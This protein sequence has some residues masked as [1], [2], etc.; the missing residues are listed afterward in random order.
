MKKFGIYCRYEYFYSTGLAFCPWFKTKYQY[1]TKEEAEEELKNVQNS[2]KQI[3]KKLKRKY[4]YEI[5]EF[6]FKPYVYIKPELKE[7]K[8]RGRK[9]KE[10]T[11]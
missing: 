4:E 5:R 11:I 7:P 1:D 9:P 10:K 3:S 6:D 8:K 2:T